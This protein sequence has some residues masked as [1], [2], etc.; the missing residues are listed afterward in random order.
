MPSA[1]VI[2]IIYAG[3]SPKYA[4]TAA[5]A[6]G[7]QTVFQVIFAVFANASKLAYTQHVLLTACIDMQ[8]QRVVIN[9]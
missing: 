5:T 7:I 9:C 1:A 4:T 2:T 3:E 6:I 8:L